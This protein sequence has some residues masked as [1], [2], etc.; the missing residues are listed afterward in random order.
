MHNARSEAKQLLANVLQTI[1]EIPMWNV[2]QNAKST[3]IVLMTRLVCPNAAE[4][5]AQDLVERVLIVVWLDIILYVAVLLVILVTHW[6]LV[7]LLLPGNQWRQI[8]V[9]QIHADLTVKNAKKKI[10]VFVLASLDT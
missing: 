5:L 6:N 8:L 10:I 4:I 9:I 3:M 2:N 7:G 1:L